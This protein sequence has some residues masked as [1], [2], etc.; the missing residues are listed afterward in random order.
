[1]SPSPY[2]LNSSNFAMAVGLPN[3]NMPSNSNKLFDIQFTIQK[4]VNGAEV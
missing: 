4:N 2:L 1:M 3:V